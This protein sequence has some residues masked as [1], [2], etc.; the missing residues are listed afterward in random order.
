[1]LWLVGDQG[2]GKSRLLHLCSRPAHLGL[3]PALPTFSALGRLCSLG[4][5]IAVDDAHCFSL[6]RANGPRSIGQARRALLLGGRQRGDLVPVAGRASGGA[7]GSVWVDL[8]GPRLFASTHQPDTSIAAE[9]LV[10]PWLRTTDVAR[11]ALDP[12]DPVAWPP[13]ILLRD[14]VDGL[15]ALALSRLRGA[16]PLPAS[17]HPPQIQ[18]YPYLGGLRFGRFARI[19]PPY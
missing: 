10:L 8:S 6:S 15:W 4:A 16:Q 17:V 12:A 3:L 13:G 19:M 11:A 1:M 18:E 2:A 5:A 9:C 14:L 7:A